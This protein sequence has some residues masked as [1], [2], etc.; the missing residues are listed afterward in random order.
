MRRLY[1]VEAA[2]GHPVQGANEQLAV[3]MSQVVILLPG[4]TGVPVIGVARSVAFV[5]ALQAFC[6]GSGVEMSL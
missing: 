4:N 5:A 6:G 2:F 1:S 3:F